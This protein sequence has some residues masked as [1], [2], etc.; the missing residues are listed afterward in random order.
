MFGIGLP[1][2]ILIMAIALIVVGPEKLP[3][4]AKA[5]GKGIIELKKAASSLQESF[6]EEDEKPPAWD[7]KDRTGIN[8]QMNCLRPTTTFQKMPCRRNLSQRLAKRLTLMQEQVLQLKRRII[9]HLLKQKTQARKP[10]VTHDH[11]LGP[12]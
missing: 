11:D 5:L 7:Q 9:P 6:K 10:R 8:S 4:L 12:P 3:E 2:L 1:E